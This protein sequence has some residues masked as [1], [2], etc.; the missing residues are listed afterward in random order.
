MTDEEAVMSA[1]RKAIEAKRGDP[2]FM[3]R[4]RRNIETHADLLD[5]LADG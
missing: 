4:L 3:G 5:R 2:E 1:L